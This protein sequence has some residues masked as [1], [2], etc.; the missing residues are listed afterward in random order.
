M[1]VTSVI[2][3]GYVRELYLTTNREIVL[4]QAC[5][6]FSD[7]L[8]LVIPCFESD[9]QLNLYI[10]GWHDG[11]HCC[12]WIYTSIQVVEIEYNFSVAGIAKNRRLL[13][14][15]DVNERLVCGDGLMSRT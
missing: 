5:L 7:G 8:V 14:V 15:L 12:S 13:V 4:Q 6:D 3:T 10:L 9:W 2:V 1:I 11:V